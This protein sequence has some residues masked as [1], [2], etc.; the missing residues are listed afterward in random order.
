MHAE[1]EAKLPQ[2][3]EL[4]EKY[5]VIRLELFGSATGPEF[6]P[7]TSDFDFVAEFENA[8]IDPRYGSRFIGFADQLETLLARDTDVITSRSIK[9][10]FFRANVDAARVL[11]Y[12]REDAFA[13]S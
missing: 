4:C 1:I 9:N 12:D 6:D 13:R 7:E 5:G 3:K 10:R 11:V 8:E 2:I